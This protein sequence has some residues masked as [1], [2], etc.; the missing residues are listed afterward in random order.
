MMDDDQAETR[1]R[2]A[3]RLAL[4]AALGRPVQHEINNLLTVIFAN[5]DMLK[6]RVTDEAPQRQIDRV[7]QA[8]RRFEASSR[9][10]LALTRRP[11][12]GE[13]LVSPTVAIAAIEPLLAV[14]L[15]APGALRIERP[16]ETPRCRFDQALLDAGLLGL[17]QAAAAGKGGLALAL[18][19]AAGQVVLQVT[20][21]GEA[22]DAE[23][24]AALARLAAEARGSFS[25]EERQL[26]IA[27]PVAAA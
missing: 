6:R 4:L 12:P 17:A 19:E 15:P 11:V 13:A 26:R 27:L 25:A 23:A 5:L 14:L 3:D 18:S 24:V 10:I 20:L 8:A 16:A 21:A 7:Q 1:Q 2:Q 22:R 9:A